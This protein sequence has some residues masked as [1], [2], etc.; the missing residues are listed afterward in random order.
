[1]AGTGVV[2]SVGLASCGGVTGGSVAKLPVS[3]CLTLVPLLMYAV[4]LTLVDVAVGAT[5]RQ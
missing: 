2:L 1:V 5:Q 3:V 4:G